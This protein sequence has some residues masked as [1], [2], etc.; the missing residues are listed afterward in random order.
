MADGSDAWRSP[1][2]ALRYRVR[3]ALAFRRGP[4]ALRQESKHDLFDYLAGAERNRAEARA[5]ELF[6][7][8]RLA[9]LAELS[10][11]DDYRDN[12]YLLDALEQIVGAERPPPELARAAKVVDVGSK[13]F[14]YAFALERFF[15]HHRSSRG[16]PVALA[17]VEIDGHVIY[18]DFRARCDYAEAYVRQLANPEVTYQVAD[19]FDLDHGPFNAVTLLFPFVQQTALLR[20]GLPLALF[21]PPRLVGKIDEVLPAGWLVALSQTEEEHHALGE[22]LGATRARILVRTRIVSK[23]V[24]YHEATEDRWGT[25]AVFGPDRRAR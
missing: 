11:R 12:L 7:R 22:L 4:P 15:R 6:A 21:D 3:R 8:Y 23:L 25:L 19:F 18:R 14:S 9:A 10:T 24:A 17:G 1:F 2:N 5:K 16:R 13:N 20:W